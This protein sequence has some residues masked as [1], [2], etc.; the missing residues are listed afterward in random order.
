MGTHK[1]RRATNARAT[2]H[3]GQRRVPR[4]DPTGG[5]A[6]DEDGERRE[7]DGSDRPVAMPGPRRAD[8]DDAAGH[9][10]R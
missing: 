5:R 10:R 1:D 4:T 7:L 2:I 9:R 8:Q 3:R 6:D